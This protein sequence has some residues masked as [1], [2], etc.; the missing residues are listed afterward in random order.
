[1]RWQLPDHDTRRFRSKFAWLPVV[2]ENYRI[3]LEF[4]YSEEMYLSNKWTCL[5]KFLN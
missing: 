4:Y 3:W 5:R 1:M 2:V